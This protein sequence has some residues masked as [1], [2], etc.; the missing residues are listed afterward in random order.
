MGLTS[1]ERVVPPTTSTYSSANDSIKELEDGWFVRQRWEVLGPLWKWNI[2]CVLEVW[3][4][5][6]PNESP[7]SRR[8]AEMAK[9]S[10][11]FAGRIRGSDGEAAATAAAAAAAAVAAKKRRRNSRKARK[12]ERALRVRLEACS[13]PNAALTA[14]LALAEVP[15]SG[16]AL[17]RYTFEADAASIPGIS[18][19]LTKLVLQNAVRST[20]RALKAESESEARRRDELPMQNRSANLL[21]AESDP[22]LPRRLIPF[23]ADQSYDDDAQ[24]VAMNVRPVREQKRSLPPLYTSLYGVDEINI[25]DNDV[26][27]QKDVEDDD[28]DDGDD[29]GGRR[30]RKESASSS[31]L[32]KNGSSLAHPPFGPSVGSSLAMPLPLPVVQATL[33]STAVRS[34]LDLSSPLSSLDLS[35]VDVA[36]MNGDVARVP[37]EVHVRRID[38][39]HVRAVCVAQLPNAPTHA[40]KALTDHRRHAEVI[41]WLNKKAVMRRVE[42]EPGDRRLLMVRSEVSR[43]R[44]DF[45][46]PMCS[47]KA[48]VDLEVYENDETLESSF[49]L[50]E[51]PQKGADVG[52]PGIESMVQSDVDA[53]L[54]SPTIQVL[55]GKWSVLP[56]ASSRNTC[57]VRVALEVKVANNPSVEAQ[58]AKLRRRKDAWE[59]AAESRAYLP[60][61]HLPDDDEVYA[62]MERCVYDELPRT[63][64]SLALCARDEASKSGVLG[65]RSRRYFDEVPKRYWRELSDLED[66]INEVIE[67]HDLPKKTMPPMDFLYQIGNNPLREA[68]RRW[69]G[70][71]EVAWA[72]NYKVRTARGAIVDPEQVVIQLPAWEYGEAREVRKDRGGVVDVGDDDDND[73][74]AEGDEDEDVEVDETVVLKSRGKLRLLSPRRKAS[75]QEQQQPKKKAE[76]RMIRKRSRSK[77]DDDPLALLSADDL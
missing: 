53:M 40:W 15:E 56:V 46:D 76:T 2:A 61:D 25:P 26:G 1:L 19:E 36:T 5:E 75:T 41:P 33:D 77:K 45:P 54:T 63:I 64:Q 47:W 8:E 23:R 44:R 24:T 4:E 34:S 43:N 3:E 28:D 22:S 9:Q 10:T 13:I 57:Q 60:C 14:R 12:T 65:P 42:P 11:K 48:T 52:T 16:G 37:V 66:A 59:G 39:R 55:R 71:R 17:T 50:H 68:I 32:T 35:D 51:R 62:E 74:D 29:D 69:G 20:L 18:D 49:K 27:E 73:D 38:D 6:E 21:D 72:L 31:A 30:T 7:P 58:V 67:E 70:S